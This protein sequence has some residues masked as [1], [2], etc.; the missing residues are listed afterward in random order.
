MA[1][2]S[3]QFGVMSEPSRCVHEVSTVSLENKIDQLTNIVYSLIAGRN[4]PSRVCG[5]CTMPDHPTDYCP[6]LQGETSEIVFADGTFPGPPQ[7][8]YNPYCNTYNLGWKEHPN[9]SYAQ[10]QKPNQASQQ[11]PYQQHYQQ[12]QKTSLEL[13]MEKMAISQESMMGKMMEKLDASQEKSESRFQELEKQVSQL[14]QTVGRLESLGVD[15]ANDANLQKEGNATSQKYSTPEPELSPYV[16]QPPLPSKFIKYNKQPQEKEILDVF[17]KVKI[18]IPLIEVIRKL[19]RY[20]PFLKE[21]CAN[22]RKFYGHEK[23]NRGDNIF[24]VFTRRLTSML[25]N[26]G[27]FATPRNIN[28]ISLKEVL[29]WTKR[30]R[31]RKLQCL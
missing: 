20:A 3:Q 8:P 19:P 13:M 16:V 23:V 31:Q 11:R 2:Y 26:Q 4:E 10:N 18:N 9:F 6:I 21:F 22:K 15:E 27:M 30:K 7:I 12:P 17:R 28:R 29:S 14:A 5:I 24:A 25:K 1:A